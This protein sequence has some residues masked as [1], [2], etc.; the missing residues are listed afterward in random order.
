MAN[1]DLDYNVA[2]YPGGLPLAAVLYENE[3]ANRRMRVWFSA[4]PVV[5]GGVAQSMLD[6]NGMGPFLEIKCLPGTSVLDGVKSGAACD[7]NGPYGGPIDRARPAGSPVDP[8]RMVLW[9]STGSLPLRFAASLTI[10][11][12]AGRWKI[13]IWATCDPAESEDPPPQWCEFSRRID[14]LSGAHAPAFPNVYPTFAVDPAGIIV[15]TFTAWRYTLL[16][17]D[18]STRTVP[19]NDVALM[20]ATGLNGDA[21]KVRVG[22]RLFLSYGVLL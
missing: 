7:A 15:P 19:W 22:D 8:S 1:T 18:G 5:I 3:R 21:V 10:R 12:G 16:R 11:G 20:A 17:A 14:C 6:A 4:L 9:M 2:L 13:R